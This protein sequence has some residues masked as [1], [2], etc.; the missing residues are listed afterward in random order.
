MSAGNAMYATRCSVSIDTQTRTA[1]TSSTLSAR[2][3]RNWSA[4]SGLGPNH[5][6]A[7]GTTIS[8]PHQSP[9]HH[10]RETVKSEDHESALDATSDSGPITALAA[11]HTASAI[12]SARDELVLSSGEPRRI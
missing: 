9:S 3:W 11:V 4:R 5:A 2:P 1:M 12:T 7:N 8:A 10:V 6:S